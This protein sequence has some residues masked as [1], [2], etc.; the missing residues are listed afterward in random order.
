MGPELWGGAFEVRRWEPG[1]DVVDDVYCLP[2]RD[3]GQW[4]VFDRNDHI[5]P[6]TINREHSDD[7]MMGQVP[8][9]YT[10][11]DAVEER[12]ANADYLYAGRYAFHFGHFLIESLARLWPLAGGKAQGQKIVAHGGSGGD[13]WFSDPVQAEILG[14][15]NL[16][17]Q[18]FV[19][20]DRAFKLDRLVVPHM[21]FQQQ[22]FGHHA[23]GRLCRAIG[24]RLVGETWPA[25]EHTPVWL[26]KST[27]SA[28]VRKL[29]NEDRIEEVLRA[30]GVDIVHPEDLS[31]V[32]KVK[33][34]GSRTT[35]LGTLQSAHN[36]SIFAPPA[37]RLIS[38]FPYKIVG[39]DHIT[40]DVL[41]GNDHTYLAPEAC[42]E[43]FHSGSPFMV[44][45][46]VEDPVG[47]A[48]ELLRH[49]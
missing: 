20:A 13:G 24:A 48:E 28:G 41:N 31:F 43:T 7:R 47:V 16:A 46:E 6:S 19:Y 38:L 32:E 36:V 9:S 8:S 11:H 34:F 3:G 33:L 12:L 27:L 22:R 2:H 45:A 30:N 1:L 42:T 18:D 37:G 39:T 49:I 25:K 10:N 40:I 29:V 35:I 15:L 17:P 23:Y 21:A 26:S 14:A 5:V 4:G 44:T